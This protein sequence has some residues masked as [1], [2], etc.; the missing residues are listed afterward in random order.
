MDLLGSIL[1]N[2]DKPPT[3]SEREK[4]AAKGEGEIYSR[5]VSVLPREYIFCIHFY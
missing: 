4:K 3:A 1:S 5:I 2:M